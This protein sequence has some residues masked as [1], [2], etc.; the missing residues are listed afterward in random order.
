MKKTILVMATVLAAQ[1]VS[2]QT[3]KQGI[4]SDVTRLTQ[5]GTVKYENPRWSP[6]GS[7]IAFTQF[8][9]EGLYVMN[10]D[11]SGQKQLTDG[12]GV[13]YLY[14]WCA[15][16]KEILIRD[17]R[18]ETT[19]TGMIRLHAAWT[20]TMTGAKTKLTQDAEYMQ[21]AAWRYSSTG[22]RSVMSL[23]AKALPV[24]LSPVAK[25]AIDLIRETPSAN[26]SFYI[27]A[28]NDKLYLVKPNGTQVLINSG[29]P[30]FNAMLS[31][32]GTKVVFNQ[33]DDMYI[34]N[35][36]GSGKRLLARGFNPQWV[37]DNQ[38]I[39]E[40]TNDNGHVY[41]SGELYMINADGTSLKQLTSTTD[42]IEMNPCVSPDGTKV[43]FTS[44][45]DGQVYIA[46]LK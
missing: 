38:L 22:A 12:P 8:G 40:L 25:S 23:D 24:Q 20:I 45:T 30:S 33:N 26:I 10:A 42:K 27:D 5:D 44:F 35:A 3:L 43:V 46:D 32:D 29:V 6:D 17:T 19:A 41:T 39:F 16:S 7:K 9:Y 28:V 31:P 1:V 37:N 18:W 15:D 14:Q 13:G 11:G 4:L 21:P 2:A 36:D 34:V